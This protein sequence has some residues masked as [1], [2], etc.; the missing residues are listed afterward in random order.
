MHTSFVARVALS[1]AIVAAVFCG[2]MPLA[3]SAG[4]LAPMMGFQFFMLGAVFG[5]IALLLGLIGVVTTRASSGRSGRA[6]ALIAMAIGAA[7][8]A[9]VGMAA[10]PGSGLPPINDISTDLEDPP[11]FFALAEVPANQGRDLSHPGEAMAQ[12]QRAG[13]PDLA[14][15]LVPLPPDEAF[16]R[17]AAEVET[18]GWQVAR[19]EAERGEIEATDTSAIF[20]FVDDISIRLRPVD[21]GTRVDMRSKSRDGQGDL[22]ANAARIRQLRDAL[23]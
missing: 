4:V 10:R 22:G 1:M 9:G 2:L 21:E 5:G 14:P 11:A 6:A 13:Y 15:I 19:S 23:L 18:L 17:V 16:T 12:Q 20:R 8:V 7:I 3:T